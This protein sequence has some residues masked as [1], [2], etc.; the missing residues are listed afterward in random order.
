M[1]LTTVPQISN[2]G[3]DV[4]LVTKISSVVDEDVGDDVELL[5]DPGRPTTLLVNDVQLQTELQN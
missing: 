5:L 1:L 2:T 4:P 3:T